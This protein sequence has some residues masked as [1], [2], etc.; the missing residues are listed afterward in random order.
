MPTEIVLVRHGLCTGNA[1]GLASRKGDQSLF[2]QEFRS[3]KSSD[4]TLLPHG[5][6]QAQEAGEKIRSAVLRNFDHFIASDI[7]RSRET[8]KYL[9]FSAVWETDILLRERDWGGTES[10][11]YPERKN[12]FERNGISLT[13]DSMKWNPP[14][15]ESML[16]ILGQMRIFLKKVQQRFSGKRILIVSHGGPIQAIRVL[17]HNVNQ[18]SYASFI[19]GNNYIRNCHIFHYFSKKNDGCLL[20]MYEYEHSLYLNS[21]NN[22]IETIV[23][24]NSLG[25]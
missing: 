14:G 8:A 22:W 7:V 12:I 13:E 6:W 21:D 17:Q 2:T 4:W 11:P 16:L 24:L 3:Q 15:G 9:G 20:P 23:K 18:T 5:I 25:A 1:A 10:L 19:S